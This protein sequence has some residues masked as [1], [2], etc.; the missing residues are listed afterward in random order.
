MKF[1]KLTIENKKYIMLVYTEKKDSIDIFENNEEGRNK[2]L[3]FIWHMMEGDEDGK[4]EIT[5]LRES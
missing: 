1:S 4:D 2:L 3:D 5:D